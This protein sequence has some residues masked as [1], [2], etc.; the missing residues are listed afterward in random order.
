MGGSFTKRVMDRASVHFRQCYQ[1]ELQRDIELSG[2]VALN[3]VIEKNAVTEA[4]IESST[5]SNADVE[6]CLV[7]EISS[8]AVSRL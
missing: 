7:N 2:K 4:S 1:R 6:N 8:V 5:L 3:F